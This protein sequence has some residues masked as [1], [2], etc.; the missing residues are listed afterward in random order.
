MN[1]IPSVRQIR[2]NFRRNVELGSWR[3][4]PGPAP[5]F[6]FEGVQRDLFRFLVDRMKAAERER[7]RVIGRLRTPEAVLRHAAWVRR[8]F[9][10]VQGLAE[11]PPRTPLN[12]RVSFGFEEHGIR[13]LRVVFE[14]RPRFYVT[15]NLYL[16][17]ATEP[18]FPAV[19][20]VVGHTEAGKQSPAYQRICTALAQKDIA[21]LAIDPAGQGERDEYV[22]ITT[23][24]RTVRRACRMHGVAGDPAY[25]LG[26]NFGGYRLWD[27]MR[28]VDYLQGREDVIPSRIGVAG[29]SGGG[30]EALWLGAT[31]TRI[32]AI[33]TN[34]YLTT[35]RRRVENRCAD[36]EPDP[37]QDPFG[38]LA[39][40]LDAA[41]LLLA[42]LPRAVSIGSTTRDFFPLDGG[43]ACFHE[44]KRLF[45]IAGAGDRIA[46][47]MSDAGHQTTEAL[48]KQTYRWMQ[49]WLRDDPDPDDSEPLAPLA[50]EDR[51]GWC[52]RT[53]IVLTSL[54]GRTTAEL[55]AERARELGL[56]R[57]KANRGQ[58]PG[59]RAKAVRKRLAGLLNCQR[60]LGAT[61][62]ETGRRQR[63]CGITLTELRLQT[64]G[65]L[66]L[67]GHM[68]QGRGG[69]EKTAVIFLSAKDK[70]YDAAANPICRVLAGAGVLVLDLDPRGMGPFEEKWLDFVPLI[71]SDLTYDA[72]LL[73]RPLLGMRVDDI[74]RAVDV[75]CRT[76]PGIAPGRIGLYGVGYGALLALFAGC[77]DRRVG[78]VVEEGG[79]ASYGS[80]TW[81]RD[82]AWPISVILPGALRFFD[83]DDV[84][85]S[86]APRGLAVINPVNRLRLPLPRKEWRGE[87][88]LAREAYEAAGMK[89][90]LLIRTGV[91]GWRE[92]VSIF[93]RF[94]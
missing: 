54:G 76:S 51:R 40:G 49:R 28:A 46:M 64:E 77:L 31:D 58:D 63:V 26:A 89:K 52:T 65:G 3:R 15:A 11:L 93:R 43:V 33:N 44:A 67:S 82:Y 50:R 7:R 94:I 61:P 10:E 23:G 29:S 83:L 79:L 86:L 80:L 41:D 42:C 69:R 22:D 1:G 30:W 27:C 36:A 85:A 34:V 71:E 32:R 91:E 16:P 47:T 2:K 56:R 81:H 62:V 74:R 8:V 57:R 66:W 53:G 12:P 73:G 19:L 90:R 6:E 88:G 9:R 18:P 48:R 72:F 37:E 13:L 87:F 92:T 60:E 75:I 21:V 14:S 38:V 35:W 59:M 55:N 68:W 5:R 84:R 39:Q 20:Y 45:G 78:F 70:D 4:K 17:A 25:L 24:R